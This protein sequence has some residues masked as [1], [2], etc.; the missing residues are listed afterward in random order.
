[1]KIQ[2]NIFIFYLRIIQET[3]KCTWH[4]AFQQIVNLVQIKM[5]QNYKS[6]LQ[7]LTD[8][9]CEKCTKVR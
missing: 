2:I 8:F 4:K 6:K 1:M 5:F 9:N 7:I 3:K